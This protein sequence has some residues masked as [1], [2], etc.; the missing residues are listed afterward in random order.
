M[1]KHAANQCEEESAGLP[2][3]ALCTQSDLI[4]LFVVIVYSIYIVV[5]DLSFWFHQMYTRHISL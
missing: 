4:L 1:N 3:T 2:Y 5:R